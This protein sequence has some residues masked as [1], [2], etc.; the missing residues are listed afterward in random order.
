L[1]KYEEPISKDECIGLF[2]SQKAG[3]KDLLG[4]LCIKRRIRWRVV[5]GL[6]ER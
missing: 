3:L 1:Q 6:S 5:Y 2:K 4:S